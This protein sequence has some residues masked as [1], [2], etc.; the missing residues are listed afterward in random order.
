MNLKRYVLT[1]G[2]FI[3]G[4]ITCRSGYNNIL[5]SIKENLF[6]QTE[7]PK[8]LEKLEFGF[9]FNGRSLEMAV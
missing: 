9:E 2:N 8:I 4:W 3:A 5:G 7:Y 6:A 1:D